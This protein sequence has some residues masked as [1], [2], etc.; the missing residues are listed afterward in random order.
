MLT[1]WSHFPSSRFPTE[2]DVSLMESLFDPLSKSSLRPLID[3]LPA[4]CHHSMASLV[5]RK[6]F[7]E[8]S[9]FLCAS[10]LWNYLPPPRLPDEDGW[11]LF[12]YHVNNLLNC[13]CDSTL[14]P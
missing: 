14:L 8:D 2:Y 12:K 6:L 3:S 5:L 1:P 7:N 9:F 13:S 10:K 11:P 4:I